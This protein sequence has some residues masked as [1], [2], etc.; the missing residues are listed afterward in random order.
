MGQENWDG[1]RR[2]G[3]HDTTLSTGPYW[4]LQ[5]QVHQYHS[6]KQCFIIHVLPPEEAVS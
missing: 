2:D 6:L 5:V 3:C 1:T 4:T